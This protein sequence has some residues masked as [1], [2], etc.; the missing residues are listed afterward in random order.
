MYANAANREVTSRYKFNVQFWTVFTRLQIAN[1]HS[2]QKSPWKVYVLVF[3]SLPF[4]MS[5][6]QLSMLFA[7]SN[8]ET[9]FVSSLSLSTVV[10][11]FYCTGKCSGRTLHVVE[12]ATQHD[13][14]GTRSNATNVSFAARQ[15]IQWLFPWIA[16]HVFSKLFWVTFF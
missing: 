3:Y 13:C 16:E 15:R 1:I 9:S 6:A 12:R 10:F 11:C 14:L 4:D 7:W 5:L 8:G 2:L